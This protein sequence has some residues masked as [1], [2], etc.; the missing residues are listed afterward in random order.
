MRSLSLLQYEKKGKKQFTQFG[1][2]NSLLSFSSSILSE[3]VENGIMVI[4]AS[5]APPFKLGLPYVLIIDQSRLSH[6]L[7]EKYSSIC[8][9]NCP[10]ASSKG[11]CDVTKCHYIYNITQTWIQ[12]LG[13]LHVFCMPWWNSVCLNFQ[14]KKLMVHS[15]QI[16][17][18]Y[19]CCTF[20]ELMYLLSCLEI[21]GQ[22]L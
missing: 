10:H 7:N 22:D 5:S 16:G 4:H 8:K 20:N 14:T 9:F 18:P 15:S 13:S 2:A 17:F 21:T 11:F 3:S 1:T 6:F 19:C 12:Y